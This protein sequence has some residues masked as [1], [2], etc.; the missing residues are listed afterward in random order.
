MSL[1]IFPSIL[2]AD[3][4]NLREE[5]KKLDLA[6]AD[7]IHIDVMDGCFVPNLTFGPP[8][9]ASIRKYTDLPFDVHLMIQEPSRYIKEY[10]DAGADYITVHLESETHIVS[11]LDKIRNYGVKAGIS[12]VP[13]TTCNDLEYIMD[14]IDVILIMTV[15]P[16]FSGQKFLHSQLPKIHKVKKMI[17]T[18]NIKIFVDGGINGDTVKF[19]R[20][21]GVDAV[22][23][24]SYI[25]SSS[26][27]QSNI[28]TL[29]MSLDKLG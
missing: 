14:H 21:S 25:F 16:G 28:N 24:G 22:I 7:S 3:L 6:G 11:L 26:D 29:K 13:S 15:N 20:H 10:V 2:S 18:K 8:V 9:I 19:I 12:I 4:S 27:Y 17:G 23:S 5:V 1:K